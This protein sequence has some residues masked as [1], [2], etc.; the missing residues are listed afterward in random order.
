MHGKKMTRNMRKSNGKDKLFV[1][2]TQ[3]VWWGKEDSVIVFRSSKDLLF[4]YILVGIYLQ[5]KHQK[6]V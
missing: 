1:T 3:G 6:N 5:W 4:T 2:L